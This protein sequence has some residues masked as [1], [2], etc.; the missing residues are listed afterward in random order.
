MSTKELVNEAVKK[1]GTQRES[2]MAILQYICE[3]ERFL[4]KEAMQ[5]VATK[6][7]ISSA[8]VYGTASFYSFLDIKERGENIIRV[9]RTITCDMA[10][11]EEI[12]KALE[13]KLRIKIGGTTTDKKFTLLETNCLG[14]CHKGPVMLINDDVYTELTPESAIKALEKYSKEL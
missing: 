9:C 14:W 4:S 10:G 3:K 7:D 11:K 2:L 12:I 1:F 8:D 13:S 6:L 5:E